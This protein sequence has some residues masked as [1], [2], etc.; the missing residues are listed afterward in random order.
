MFHIDE[1]GNEI[2]I[3]FA[4]PNSFTTDYVNFLSNLPSSLYIRALEPTKIYIINKSDLEILYK[5]SIQFQQLGRIIAEQFFI[6]FPKRIRNSSL[7]PEV[8]YNQIIAEKQHC[9]Q[10]I[11]QYKIA[12]YLNISP[13]W[14]SKIRSKK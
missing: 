12:S 6:E 4:F 8:R 5:K 3:D 9:I 14:L 1:L 11:T 13:E 2:S 10:N 7:P